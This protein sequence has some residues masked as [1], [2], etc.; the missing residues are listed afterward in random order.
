MLSKPGSYIPDG[1][2]KPWQLAALFVPY[3]FAILFALREIEPLPRVH[4]FWTAGAYFLGGLWVLIF[5]VGLVR[6]IPTWTLPSV[7]MVLFMV[8]FMVKWLIQGVVVAFSSAALAG[9]PPSF[10]WPETLLGRILVV[11]TGDL[12]FLA[13]MLLILAFILKAAPPF[14]A[15]VRQDRTLLS[16]LIYSMAIPLMIF[17]DEF[18]SIGYYE[19]AAVLI[20]VAGTGLFMALPSRRMRVLVLVLAVLLSASILSFGMYQVFPEQAFARRAASF[21][22]WESLQPLLE[23]PALLIL[24]CLPIF[25]PRLPI[26]RGTLPE[27]T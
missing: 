12:L 22:L 8:G 9:G 10:A 1:P 6:G 14:L 24:I 11:L 17:F 27:N 15:R 7:G 21:R 13:P 25:F 26:F 19:L 5:G 23:L 4:P 2:F 18:R 3:L 20:L 16:L